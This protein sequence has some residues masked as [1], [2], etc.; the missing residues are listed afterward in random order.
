MPRP[1]RILLQPLPLP[2]GDA[3]F[4]IRGCTIGLQVWSSGTSLAKLGTASPA[5]LKFRA[6]CLKEALDTSASQVLDLGSITGQIA[7]LR[8]GGARFTIQGL[9]PQTNPQTSPSSSNVSFLRTLELSFRTP[10]FLAIPAEPVRLFL[11]DAELTG[12]RHVELSVELSIGGAVEAAASVNDVLDVPLKLEFLALTLV[13]EVGEP[14]KAEAISLS[15]PRDELALTTDAKGQ[16]RVQNPPGGSAATLGFPSEDALRKELQ[17]RWSKVRNKV[18]LNGS[19]SLSVVSLS[20]AFDQ[21]IDLDP[22]VRTVSIQ[23]RVELARFVG[24][25]FDTAKTFLLPSALPELGKLQPLYDAHP[26]STLLIVGHADRAGSSSY[27][28]VLS[29]DRAEAIAAFLRDD[30]SGFTKWYGASIPKEKRWGDHEDQLMLHALSDGAALFAGGDA[31]QAFRNTRKISE[32]G[33]TGPATRQA[34]VSEYMGLDGATLPSTIEVVTHGCGENFPDLPTPDGVDEEENRRVEIFFFDSG[35]GVQ[36]KP[37]GKNSK[38]GSQDYPEWRRRAQHT[39]DFDLRAGESFL[40]R[41]KLLDSDHQPLAG[42]QW[43]ILHE[44]GSEVGTTDSSGLLVARIPARVQSAVL[45]HEL[46]SADLSLD[47]VP[48]ADTLLGAQRRLQNLGYDC[49]TDG[50]LG[51]DTKQAIS[52]FQQ[53]YGLAETGILDLPTTDELRQV[54]GQ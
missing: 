3:A 44:F 39:H 7:L 34:L 46:G 13:D 23:P 9:P 54:Y 30:A 32:T 53:D 16:V 12:F 48:P 1:I 42:M 5:E 47:L 41:L 10:D 11:N 25:F 43:S 31:I 35:F 18:T 14:L 22:G 8:G 20:E 50:N 38:A 49:E 29:L 15:F 51:P 36:P 27:N 17:T 6:T 26:N 4:V 45:V 19:R 28:D 40:L 33:P 24:L 21:S 37:A 52:E 2:G